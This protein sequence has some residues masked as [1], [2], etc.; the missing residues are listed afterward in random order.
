M[1]NYALTIFNYLL[2][3]GFEFEEDVIPDVAHI[4]LVFYDSM[5]NWIG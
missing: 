1:I 2:R 4:V 5:L 3:R